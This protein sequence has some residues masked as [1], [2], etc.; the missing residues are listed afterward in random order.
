MYSPL[1]VYTLHATLDRQSVTQSSST[2]FEMEFS[3]SSVVV[4]RG[5]WTVSENT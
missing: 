1:H 5:R 4:A 3:R 2:Y